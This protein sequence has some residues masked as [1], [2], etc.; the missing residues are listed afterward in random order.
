[1]CTLFCLKAGHCLVS[2][3]RVNRLANGP[4]HCQAVQACRVIVT[5]TLSCSGDGRGQGTRWG[6]PRKEVGLERAQLGWACA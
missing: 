6:F 1:M 5:F 4:Q 2:E 3:M